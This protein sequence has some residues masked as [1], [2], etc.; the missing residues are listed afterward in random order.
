MLIHYF[1][2]NYPVVNVSVNIDDTYKGSFK[3][4][5]CPSTSG[6]RA[7]VAF[8]N[9]EIFDYDK[10][11]LV[12]IQLASNDRDIW[13][14]YALV[15]PST[16][17]T[18][19]LMKTAPIDLISEF[20][21]K[22]AS[23][24]FNIEFGKNDF[25]DQA[26]FSLSS[27]YNNGA[28]PCECNQEG[29]ITSDNCEIFGGQCECKSNVVGRQCTKC[30]P[31]YYGF[32]DCRKCNCP[33]RNCDDKT[34][35]CSCPAN[36]IQNDDCNT[37]IPGY[38]G[39][40]PEHGCV[41]CDCSK[42]G[43]LSSNLNL[44]DVKTGQCQC[45]ENI[46]GLN[47]EK[48]KPGFYG[49][50]YCSQCACNVNGTTETICDSYGHCSCKD[51]LHDPF[52]EACVDGTF[53]LESRNPK[54]CTKCFCFGHTQRCDSSSYHFFYSFEDM[55]ANTWKSN[56]MNGVEIV[57]LESGRLQLTID[58]ESVDKPNEPIYWIAPSTYLG[59]K[60]HSYGGAIRY[61]LL[62]RTSDSKTQSFTSPE[63][64]LEGEGMTIAY[65]SLK[66]PTN[67]DIFTN[68]IDLLES[69]FTHLSSGAAVTREQLMIVLR[70]LSN[71][72]I[73]AGSNTQSVSSAELISVEIDLAKRRDD[74]MDSEQ[75]KDE[76]RPARSVERCECPQT[77]F[78]LSCESCQP[79]YYKL[80]GSKAGSF[81]CIPCNCNGHADSCDEESGECMNCMDNT[82]GKNCEK[83]KSGYY[84][85]GYGCERCPCPGPVKNFAHN[86]SALADNT[87]QCNCQ[88][89]YTG[90]FCSSCAAGYY[91]SPHLPIE[92]DEGK[93]LQCKCNGN[94]DMN[95]IRS[96]D[97]KSGKCLKCLKN[98]TGDN[99]ERCKD[100]HWGDP[101]EAKSCTECQCDK[102]GSESCDIASGTCTCKANVKGMNCN[103]CAVS[104]NFLNLDF[105]C[106]TK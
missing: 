1:Q 48:C 80:K 47:C 5:F 59:K 30:K 69:Q 16:A 49:Y 75:S 90:L 2:P 6:C 79:G 71:L 91:G 104:R 70:N 68:T 24:H 41:A 86:C 18:P 57:A 88:V 28:K 25:C 103:S 63:V 82:E 97:Q 65:R 61:K 100:W 39:F 67:G 23:Q 76:L 14:N 95:D 102:C 9:S 62:F 19:D 72:Q 43:S 22:C 34:G 83:C 84:N 101:I 15:G 13:L 89:G 17:V 21:T 31:G 50:P 42:N 38:Y 35:K 74:D 96:C 98:T 54:G 56:K 55:N 53:N 29:S 78:G 85:N 77:Y 106:V 99:C 20:I 7:I 73:L 45:K 36:V 27:K 32:P 92:S 11:R 87:V 64:I 33:G 66:Q 10:S 46:G 26:V 51:N 94:I 3:A 44:C 37:C 58:K 93:C 8:E 105:N 4:S 40:H 81:T 52:C 60:L 12:S